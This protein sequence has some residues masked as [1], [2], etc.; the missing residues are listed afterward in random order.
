MC[1]QFSRILRSCVV[2]C[3]SVRIHTL[4]FSEKVL[5]FPYA[6]RKVP[7]LYIMKMSSILVVAVIAAMMCSSAVQ[8]QSEASTQGAHEVLSQ[9]W[10]LTIV[11]KLHNA[12][13]TVRQLSPVKVALEQS[14]QFT[15]LVVGKAQGTNWEVDVEVNTKEKVVMVTAALPHADQDDD[16]S[17]DAFT[18]RGDF[19]SG[20]G[21]G[22][23][24]N[25]VYHATLKSGGPSSVHAVLEFHD[26]TLTVY[27]SG[28]FVVAAK[29]LMEKWGPSGMFFVLFLVIKA[30]SA[31]YESKISAKK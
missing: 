21:K 11:E 3:Q 20:V 28:N 6:Q 22:T 9:A 14:P 17:G 29:T 13:A 23:F 24:N 15:T 4:M 19:A 7:F 16:E 27:A 25:E 18:L 5:N 12:E 8:A 26:R 30:F 10:E 31:W 2:C 1:S